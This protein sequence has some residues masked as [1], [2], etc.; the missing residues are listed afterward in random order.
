MV[1]GEGGRCSGKNATAVAEKKCSFLGPGREGSEWIH[2]EGPGKSRPARTSE[3]I[4]QESKDATNDFLCCIGPVQVA[5]SPENHV[6][7]SQLCI[8][9][10]ILNV[11][12]HF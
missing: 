5:V 4:H 3:E 7:S 10:I 12:T 2:Q 8:I 6:Y 1:P 11:P 9:D